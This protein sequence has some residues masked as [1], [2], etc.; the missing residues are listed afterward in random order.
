PGPSVRHPIPTNTLR[1]RSGPPEYSS[2]AFPR[3]GIA[4]PPIHPA[5]KEGAPIVCLTLSE[6][7]LTCPGIPRPP[8]FRPS[9]LLHPPRSLHPP[10]FPFRLAVFPVRI[11]SGSQGAPHRTTLYLPPPP[12]LAGSRRPSSPRAHW[13]F[14]GHFR[15]N[16]RSSPSPVPPRNPNPPQCPPPSR[17]ASALWQIFDRI[18]RLCARSFLP[19]FSRAPGRCFTESLN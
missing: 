7:F 12:A 9:F 18:S 4:Y 13:S 15:A 8:S 19:K 16:V 1:L 5:A 6:S 2:P 10:H 17:T 14:R 11:R 3:A